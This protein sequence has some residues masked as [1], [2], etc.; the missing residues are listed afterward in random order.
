LPREYPS[1]AQEPKLFDPAAELNQAI[2]ALRESRPEEAAQR[3]KEL[4]WRDPSNGTGYAALGLALLQLGDDAGSVQALERAHY[5]Q[6][7]DPH[8]LHQYG[9]ALQAAGRAG[10]AHL[11]FQSA[12]TLYAL[13]EEARG[14]L[15]A[16]SGAPGTLPAPPPRPGET[17]LPLLGLPEASLRGLPGTPRAGG[18][19]APAPGILPGSG[20]DRPGNASKPALDGP[21][22]P[23]V[24]PQGDTAPRHRRPPAIVSAMAALLA[25]ERG[26]APG[27]A[28]LLRATLQL[29]LL[30]PLAWLA[31]LLVPN[32]FAALAAPAE[33]ELRWVAV[34][35]WTGAF[36]VGAA[37]LLLAMGGQWVHGRPFC[38]WRLTPSRLFHGLAFSLPYAL[39]SLAPLCAAA[40]FWLR[41]PADLLLSAGLLLTIPVHALLAPALVVTAT[42]SPG[43]PKAVRT[44]LKQARGRFWLYAGVMATL[45]AVLGGLLAALFWTVQVNIQGS[46]E[47]VKRVFQ[48]AALCLGE[49]LWGALVTVCGMDAVSNGDRESAESG[50]RP[51]SGG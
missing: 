49:S 19:G 36:G 9:R 21:A 20:R 6:P 45:G 17:G 2:Q 13:Q 1:P 12:L 24:A 42:E 22:P 47:P 30:Q 18:N 14:R 35:L 27:F 4:L 34:L 3:L 44:S 33:G 10:E 11:R 31:V 46:G 48:V 37:P 41:L 5:L 23:A 40:A 29:W 8:V 39:L 43:V 32:A 15:G 26:E 51:P 7:D 50:E 16:A 28:G 25:G 38:R